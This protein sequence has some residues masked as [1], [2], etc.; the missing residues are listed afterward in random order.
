MKREKV[1]AVFLENIADPRSPKAS[2]RKP[3]RRSEAPSIPTRY[4][5]RKDRRLVKEAKNGE[6][7]RE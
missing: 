4:P 7:S 6:V 1:A 3:A 2:P 5:M